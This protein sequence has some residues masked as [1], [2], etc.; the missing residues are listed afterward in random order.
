[1]V[2][3][4]PN[5]IITLIWKWI[6]TNSLHCIY[7]FSTRGFRGIRNFPEKNGINLLFRKNNND[8]A[9]FQCACG[10]YGRDEAMKVAE[11]DSLIRQSLSSSSDNNTLPLNIVDVLVL[12]AIDEGI[13]LDCV[14]FLL[15]RQPD[16]LQKLLLSTTPPAVAAE[17]NNKDD[18]DDNDNDNGGNDGNSSVLVARTTNSSK[19]R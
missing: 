18:D 2:E 13:H 8:L 7:N 1:L 16:V 11:E 12:A 19:K 14:Y 3:L 9:S 15:R 5:R 6:F 17:S 4:D 10:V